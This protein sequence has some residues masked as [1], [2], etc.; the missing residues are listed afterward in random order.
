MKSWIL[1]LLTL[2]F[3][4]I[5]ALA[6]WAQF[7]AH[8][9]GYQGPG[10]I[11]SYTLWGGLRCYNNAYSGN[12]ADVFDTATQMTETLLTCSQGGVIN[13]TINPLSTTCAVSC[14][15]KTLY[16]QSGANSCGGIACV[17]VTAASVST[18]P[19]LLRNTPNSGN[20]CMSFSGSQVIK[21]QTVNFSLSPPATAE[22][23]SMRANGQGAAW[24]TIFAGAFFVAYAGHDYFNE[25]A[26]DN[27]TFAEFPASGNNNVVI[28]NAADG[29]FHAINAV[30]NLTVDGIVQVDGV[31]TNGYLGAG[32][33]AAGDVDIG[34]AG[35]V[36]Y[37]VGDICEAGFA[38]GDQTANL[39]ALYANQLAAYGGL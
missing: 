16:D 22:T 27:Q 20:L 2:P 4:A 14:S 33:T 10:D 39:A 5:S 18:W 23:V 13:Q 1:A 34:E 19:V 11:F 35:A 24:N 32:N 6:A 17:F 8:N 36:G 31:I 26:M 15:V 21:I 38:S 12:V 37:M 29:A 7:M 25:Y 28:A 3:A 30:S 9:P